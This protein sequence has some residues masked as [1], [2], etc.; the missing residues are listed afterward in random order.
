[1]RYPQAGSIAEFWENLKN[2]QDCI[3][4]VPRQRWDH[5]RYFDPDKDKPGKT[6]CKG[7]GFID[8]VKQFDP[9]FFAIS[10]REAALM[11]PQERLFLETAWNLFEETGHTRERLQQRYEGKVGVFVGAMYQHYHLWEAEP[12]SAAIVALSSYSAIAN[13]VSQC[14]NLRGPSL[15]IDTMCSSSLT[16]VHMAC[17]SLLQGECALAVAGG[18]N[19]S[20]PPNK[21]V[22][23][24]GAGII[25]SGRDSRGFS[26]GD[27]YLPA[28]GVGAVLLKPLARAVRDGDEIL[29][30]IKSTATNHGDSAKLLIDN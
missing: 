8:G 13:R 10:P 15:A 7:G 23:L 25:P 29:A 9:L 20:L 3:T 11:D 26:D 18:V 12:D 17:Q 24:G 16:A 27:G 6:Y 14:F 30:V 19:L 1:G 2:S 4:E 28:E 5:E 21:S 22:G